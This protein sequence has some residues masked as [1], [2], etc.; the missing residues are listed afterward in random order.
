MLLGNRTTLPLNAYRLNSLCGIC[1]SHLKPVVLCSQKQLHLPSALHF[2]PVPKM[3]IFAVNL[4]ESAHESTSSKKPLCVSWESHS[5]WRATR[6]K[7]S[8]E[9]MLTLIAFSFPYISSSGFHVLQ[10]QGDMIKFPLCRLQLRD[11]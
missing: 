11:I 3:N 4:Q 8:K 2:V 5:A 6:W 7:S 9:R 1:T 10:L